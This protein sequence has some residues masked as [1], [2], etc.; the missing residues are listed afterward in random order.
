[1]L[2]HPLIDRF[3][4]PARI[5]P[6]K[7]PVAQEEPAPWLLL[8]AGND[9]SNGTGSTKALGLAGA[10]HRLLMAASMHRG[11]DAGVRVHPTPGRGHRARRAARESRKKKRRRPSD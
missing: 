8:A 3:L 10:R 5:V 9:D 4:S 6:K 7:N 2:R 1:V 11:I